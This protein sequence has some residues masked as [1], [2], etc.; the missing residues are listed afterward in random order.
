MK[1]LPEMTSVDEEGLTKYAGSHRPRNPDIGI[2]RRI[3][4]HCEMGRRFPQYGSH[5]CG[6]HERILMKT[7]IAHVSVDKE[8]SRYILEVIQNSGSESSY[9]S[10]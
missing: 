1:I 2:F 4:K 6:K 9:G 5:V 10:R 8:V 7:F 3:F